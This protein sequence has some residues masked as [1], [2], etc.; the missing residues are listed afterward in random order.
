VR[1]RSA[2]SFNELPAPRHEEINRLI[3]NEQYIA[4]KQCCKT[5]DTLDD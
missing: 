3:E 4:A 2:D 1:V 5:L